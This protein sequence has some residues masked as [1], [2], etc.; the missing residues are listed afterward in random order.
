MMRVRIAATVAAT[1]L[2]W[3]PAYAH[4][5]AQPDYAAEAERIIEGLGATGMTAA[6]LM[7]GKVVYAGAFG[8]LEEGSGKPVTN[9]TLFPIAS[10]SKAFT[11]TALAM[12]VDQGKLGWDDPVR[13]YVPEFGM[14]DPWVSERFTVRDLLTHR[15][16]LGLGAG[17]LVMWP[18][19]NAK[20]PDVIN[21]LKHLKPTTGFRDGYAYDNLLYIV[22]GEVV[23]RVSGKSWQDFVT[24]DIFRPVGM[25]ACAADGSRLKPGQPLVRG[26]E[27]EAGASAGVPIDPRMEFSPTV[28]PAGGIWCPSADMMK[29][30]KFWLDGGVTADGQRL[31]SE[32]QKNELW[33]GV[34][35]VG[36]GT[37]RPTGGSTNL[38]MYALGWFVSDMEGT[39]IV[40]HSGGAPGV[41]SNLILIPQRNIAVFASSNDYMST[42]GAWTRQIADKLIDGK[43]DNDVIAGAIKSNAE[44]NAAAKNAVAAAAAPPKNAKKPSLPASAYAGTYR[45]P[46][47]GTVTIT[48]KRGR[49]AIDM[50][51]SELLDGPLTPYDGDTF[52]AFWPDRTMKADAFVTFAVE[53][54]KVTGI[55]MKPISDITDFSFDFQDLNLVKE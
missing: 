47:Y 3:Q 15:S 8:T 26:H 9:D 48:E 31:V 24:D 28:A 36:S 54:G 52:A 18:D 21:A 7:D 5:V 38:Q 17:D 1:A 12:L 4:K 40:H 50:S 44:V 41:T 35:P 45:D 11:T 22:A 49:L 13:K 46:W 10:I 20:A 16:G 2:A 53:D 32:K 55:T 27:R 33:K 42:A 30:A 6:V 37:I 14:Y 43:Q 34:T 23:E 39:P 51:R 19:G 29:W 25:T